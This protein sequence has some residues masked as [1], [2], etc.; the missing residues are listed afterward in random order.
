MLSSDPEFAKKLIA[1]FQAEAE[2]H[3]RVLSQRLVDLEQSPI[4]LRRRE[5]LETV[6]REAHSLKG[7]ART[8]HSTEVETFSG[9]LE[10]LFSAL[11]A[12]EAPLTPRLFD[13]LHDGLDV[14][15]ELLKPQK[16]GQTP[17]SSMSGI[18]EAMQ[19]YTAEVDSIGRKSLGEPNEPGLLEKPA[20]FQDASPPPQA[21]Q[22]HPEWVR[23]RTAKL[24]ALLLEAE[25]MQAVKLSLA[26]RVEELGRLNAA[27]EGWERS[28]RKSGS[29]IRAG[30][31]GQNSGTLGKG[32]ENLEG[33]SD[34]LQAIHAEL[35]DVER[36][37]A[38]DHRT[39]RTMAE[40]FLADIRQCL[41]LPCSALLE[42]FPRLALDL[43]RDQGKEVAF[44]VEEEEL[45]VDRRILEALRDPLTHLVRNAV[46]HGIES[47]ET[48]L[49]RGKPPRGTIL[50]K[51][52]QMD[53][54]K[55]EMVFSDDGRGID[56]QQVRASAKRIG[57]LLPPEINGMEDAEV[58]QLVFR[59]GVTTNTGV[60]ELSG[61]GLGLAIVE[62]KVRNLGGSVSLETRP[63][64][65][66]AFRMLLP[67]TVTVFRGVV[68]RRGEHSFIFP[69]LQTDRVVRWHQKDIKKIENQETITLD[70]RAVPLVPLEN[71]LGIEPRRQADK[72]QGCMYGVVV[73][74]SSGRV[75]LQV[76]EIGR[77]QEVLVRPLGI[78]SQEIK[79]VVGA[80][81][82]GAGQ[83][84]P[85]LKPEELRFSGSRPSAAKLNEPR[86]GPRSIL[87]AEDSMTTRAMLKNILEEAGF[88]VST[89]ADGVEAYARLLEE[90]VHL[91]VSDVDMPRM[92]GLDLTAKIRAD[93]RFKDVPVVLVTALSSPEDR[94]RGLAVGANAYLLKSSFDPSNLLKVIER[95]I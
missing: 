40:Q 69:T 15:G 63:G 16:D 43:A 27:L 68:V 58:C 93:H 6:F 30:N 86:N 17:R 52:A 51:I 57:L 70:G 83:V 39:F 80:A 7:A 31:L 18:L 36:R 38:S 54:A 65:G 29:S 88:H 76:D 71:A 32:S 9:A 42:P 67:V 75:A 45:E 11:K 13:L 90:P 4:E 26:E 78:I 8:V 60:T 91:V 49:Q 5:L 79:G 19:K 33:K 21:L 44:R 22:E 2:E 3:L 50:V 46:D 92:G 53:G 62:E 64:L 35:R 56:A 89:A 73:G 66:T 10:N 41:M 28:S 85:I 47:P 77:E 23:V 82:I 84:I 24:N 48:R 1:T 55:F 61:R 20:R 74:S 25:E 59:S 94:E 12:R 14:L 95:L 37:L 81:T 72:A 34:P 87:I